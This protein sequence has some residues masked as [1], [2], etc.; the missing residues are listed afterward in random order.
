MYLFNTYDYFSTITSLYLI[1]GVLDA[2]SLDGVSGVLLDKLADLVGFV[3][4]LNFAASAGVSETALLLDELGDIAVCVNFLNIAASAGVSVLEELGLSGAA[5][6]GPGRRVS[7]GDIA[8]CVNFLKI[9]ASAGVSV[10]DELGLSGAAFSGPGRR[11][12]DDVALRSNI[13]S[14]AN[15]SS[16]FCMALRGT[17][18]LARAD[19]SSFPC[20]CI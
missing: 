4:S 13:S 18:L 2:L 19:W 17:E 3:N 1:G 6:S 14:R 9:A 12:S 8:V 5:F 15:L 7:D 16:N 10:L 11:V 20:I